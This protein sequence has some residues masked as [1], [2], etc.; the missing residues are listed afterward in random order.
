MN[1]SSIRKTSGTVIGNPNTGKIIYTPPEGNEVIRDL[2]G[3]LETFIH[4]NEYWL[5]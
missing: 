4:T 3:N 5:L 2:L 1:E